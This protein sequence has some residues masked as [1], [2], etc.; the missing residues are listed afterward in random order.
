[1]K[2]DPRDDDRLY[3]DL[4]DDG[5]HRA[6]RELLGRLSEAGVSHEELLEAV[7]EERIA[8][9][10]AE[11]A[12]GGDTPYTLTQV[13]RE[14]GLD[15]GFL[16]QVLLALGRPNPRRGE[17]A[18]T[19]G[20]I[21]QAR[22]LRSFLD[23]GLP[24]RDLI[25]VCRV[26]GQGMANTAVAIR[27][28]VADALLKRGDSEL[29]LAFR[30]AEAA[31]QL[32][33]LLPPLLG[34]EL[35]AHLREVVRREAVTQAERES[36]SIRGTRPVAIAF[37]DLVDFTRL[38]GRLR[39]DELG[40]VA[41]RLSEVATEAAVPPVRIVKTIGDAV[42]LASPEVAPL[43]DALIALLNAWQKEDED[44]PKLRAGVACG[45]AINRAADW[46]GAPV[47]LASRLTDS[48]KPGTIQVDAEAQAPV[49]ERYEWTRRRR[50]ILKGVGRVS[51]FRL[52]PED[53]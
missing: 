4:G 27:E 34:H 7:R 37:A 44:F 25:E 52:K 11:L 2:T 46:F 14:A 33:P 40:G 8:A 20:D 15:P 42:M 53:S 16:R 12:I 13:A 26:L 18:F 35:L 3:A 38:G 28:L 45:P 39:P 43:L 21:E 5:D 31:E 50:K 6:R 9:L 41:G 22:I 24:R 48:A 19:D 51:Y 32:A 29:D 30:Y 17:H 49:A 1:M 23:A 36:G 10:P 47:N